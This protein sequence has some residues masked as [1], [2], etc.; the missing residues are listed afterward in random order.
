LVAN[1]WRVVARAGITPHEQRNT[2]R[3]TILSLAII[4]V[5]AAFMLGA[6]DLRG[7]DLAL[8]A[9]VPSTPPPSALPRLL[10]SRGGLDFERKSV[11]R[12]QNTGFAP[13]VYVL[14]AK[15]IGS[16]ALA[17]RLQLSVYEMTN[18]E[19][20]SLLYAGSLAGFRRLTLGTLLPNDKAK[21]FSFRLSLLSAG[22]TSADNRL[23]GLTI[24]EI[25]TWQVSS[26]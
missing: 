8:A 1:R 12:L 21:S 6:A 2:V 5:T 23:Q 16:D 3:R 26:A 19:R 24:R 7:G 25:L 18:R 14:R 15:Q 20:P 22:N 17:Q 13:G 11:V 10:V 9:G 4:A